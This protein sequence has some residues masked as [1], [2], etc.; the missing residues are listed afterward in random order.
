MRNPA[1]T[2]PWQHVLEPLHGYLTLAAALAA[3]PEDHAFQSAFN[4]GPG[5][6]SNRPVSDLVAEVLKHWPGESKDTSDPAALHEAGK[7]N[8]ATDKAFHLLG[9]QA[10]WSFEE[11]VKKTI[12][13]YRRQIAGASAWELCADQIKAYTRAH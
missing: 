4:F 9:W 8:L 13:W 10:A 6:D 7:L 11:T 5:L 12:E 2:R 1:S 3:E